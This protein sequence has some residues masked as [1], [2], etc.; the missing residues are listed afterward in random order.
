MLRFRLARLARF[1]SFAIA[2]FFAA[3]LHGAAEPAALLESDVAG[4]VDPLMTEWVDHGGAGAVVVVVGRDGPIFAKGYG[5]ADKEA[6]RPFSADRT[7]AR[8]GSI[9]KLFTGIAAM[10]LVDQGKL[11]LDRDVS[12]YVGFAIPTP[13]GGKP[14][15]MRLLLTHRAGFEEHGRDL[16]FAGGAPMPLAAWVE[17]SRPPRLFPQGDVPAYSNYGFA[18]AG[19]VVE[20][21]SGESYAEYVARHILAPLRMERSSFRQPLPETLA[22]LAAK[23]YRSR[24]KP[25]GFF[26]T[27]HAAPAGALSATGEDMGRFMRALLNDGELDGARILP[28][29]RLREMLTPHEPT[30]AGWLGLVF[31]GRRIG[32]AE[33]VGHGGGTLAFISDLELFRDQG[34]GVFVSRDGFS[35]QKEA[36]DIA[37]AIA[38]RL[39]PQAT[40]P[41]L[42]AGPADRRLE[43]VYQSTR[44]ADSSFLRASA[45][46]SQ[47]V[48]RVE[49]D[50]GLRMSSA[51]WP[52]GESRAMKPAGDNVFEGP[53]GM[54][55]A[56]VLGDP[57]YFD[58][59]AM[60]WQR[61]PW[62]L[63]AR[64]IAP[65]LLA[66]LAFGALSLV[67]WPAAALWRRWRR[68]PAPLAAGDRRLLAAARL[69]LLADLLVVAAL[70]ALFA[71]TDPSVMN[72]ALDPALIAIYA[73]AWLG[74]AGAAIALYA[75]SAFWRRRVGGAWTR[76]H[77]SALATSALMIAYVFVTFHI[78]GTTLNY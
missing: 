70:V 14:V 58:M 3:C 10:Q 45:L 40:A 71:R 59:I 69:A 41:Q 49:P 63:D 62:R 18:L 57:P 76:L 54:R 38:G 21:V 28:A 16:F 72:D 46:L 75:A 13:P 26:E 15:T 47:I 32:G 5:L 78:A 30:A 43:G 19:L 68:R 74:V 23:G 9:S 11:D 6:G 31:F 67:A 24:G 25:L 77:Q 39:L 48:V 27:I 60:R 33:A 22:P 66:S 12:D 4:V 65:A 50:G 42:A 7:L 34:L 56:P 64:W 17:K 35:D 36:P 44:R 1:F 55:L 52:F 73:L 37:R 20:R 51:A 8:P 53:G 2:V 29:A 61:V